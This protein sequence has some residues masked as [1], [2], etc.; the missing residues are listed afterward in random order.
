LENLL[1]LDLKNFLKMIVSVH[2]LSDALMDWND[3]WCTD[4]SWRNAGFSIFIFFF[5]SRRGRVEL[6]FH[7]CTSSTSSELMKRFQWIF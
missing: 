5:F 6:H 4:V 7:T 2:Y 1:P 3:I